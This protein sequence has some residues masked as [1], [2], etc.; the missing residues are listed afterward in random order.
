MPCEERHHLLIRLENLSKSFGRHKALDN[1]SLD[2]MRGDVHCLAGTN[3]CGKTTL[4]KVLSGTHAPD[5]GSRIILDDGQILSHLTPQQAHDFGV[6]VIYQDLALFPNL[7]V[8]ENIAF[9]HH[10][11]SLWGWSRHQHMRRQA[12]QII[13]ELHFELD[14]DRQVAHLSIAAR[15][16][17][18]IARALTA[19]ARLVI[20]DEPTASLA[21][22][23]VDQL[24][25]TVRYLRQ[26]NIS[27]V[28]VSHRLDEVLEISDRVTVIRDGQK[29]GTYQAQD[30]DGARLSELM[31]GVKLQHSQKLSPVAKEK[32]ILDVTNLGRKDQYRNVNFSLYKG[33]IVGLCGL[34][35]SGRTE[36]ALSLFGLTKP[37]QG[38]ISLAGKVV[39]FNNH[40]DAIKAGISYVPEDRLSLG[41]ILAQSISDNIVI[42]VLDQLRNRLCLVSQTKQ[43]ALAVQSIDQLGIRVADPALSVATLSGGNQQ[44]IV[45]AKWMLTKPKILILDCPTVGV[46]IGAKA[47]IYALIRELAAN[48]VSIILI[49]DEVNEV[50]HNCHRILHFR[51]GTVTGEYNTLKTSEKELA[52]LVNG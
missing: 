49:S 27:I 8:A 14:L 21:R 3:G 35:G 12:E 4:I 26:K 34:L 51:D 20:M 30:M 10:L 45:L 1:V 48:N 44:K 40:T 5:L 29:Q 42:T 47:S 18:A 19:K 6:Q 41:L 25:R 28:F 15:Q 46:D 33:E 50:Y 52:E 38:T 13:K 31:T 16:Q 32:I 9:D 7:S 37:D 23:E 43:N 24:L 17:V 22:H 11:G 39:Q 2:L 36:L